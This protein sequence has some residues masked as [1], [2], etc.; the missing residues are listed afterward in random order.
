VIARI[1]GVS[2]QGDKH[3]MARVDSAALGPRLSPS[4][5]GNTA[6]NVRHMLQARGGGWWHGRHCGQ[7]Q[8]RPAGAGCATMIAEINTA[9]KNHCDYYTANTGT[10]CTADPH[11]EVEGCTGFTGTNPG[12]RMLAAGDMG[13]GASEVMAFLDNPERA[14]ATWVNSVWHRLP[15][16]DPWT[17]HLG[18]GGSER[19]DTIDFRRGTPAPNDMVVLYPYAG[20]TGLPTTFDGSRGG[21]EPPE[22]S[23]GWPSASPITVYAQM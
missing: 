14:V 1:A 16:I 12:A 10:N 4:I 17:T 11:N 20:Q 19:C 2:M 8:R 21:P 15:I 22:P 13:R 7:Q 23:S 5:A 18:Y 3:A 9:A 6:L